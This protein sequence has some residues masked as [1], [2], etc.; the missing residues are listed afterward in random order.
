MK[1][2]KGVIFRLALA[3]VPREV[4]NSPG[5][6][7]WITALHVLWDLGGPNA[8]VN[9]RDPIEALMPDLV[10]TRAPRD[11]EMCK[12]GD[13]PTCRMRKRA[14]DLRRGHGVQPK[15]RSCECNLPSCRTC[16][17]YAAVARCRAR[18]QT[19]ARMLSFQE[20]A[21]RRRTKF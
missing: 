11:A 5:V 2:T 8:W 12:C 21:V 9:S 18:K 19:S 1:H 13:C 15:R 7:E 16:R 17:R 14:R 6:E 10:Q 4:L 3:N 20:W